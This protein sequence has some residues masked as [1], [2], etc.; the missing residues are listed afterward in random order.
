MFSDDRCGRVILLLLDDSAETRRQTS[1]DGLQHKPLESDDDVVDGGG[2]V[3]DEEGN[4]NDSHDPHRAEDNERADEAHRE[5]KLERACSR[6]V[7]IV[8]VKNSGRKLTV[9]SWSDGMSS[10][11]DRE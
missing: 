6:R 10:S 9:R 11:V 5:E 8:L 4:R 3:A 1:V 7:W 2:G